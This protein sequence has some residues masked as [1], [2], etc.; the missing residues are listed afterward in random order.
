[1]ILAH[2]GIDHAEL[3]TVM[4]S[5]FT[6]SFTSPFMVLLIQAYLDK[7]RDKKNRDS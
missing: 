5:L 4:V 3:L 2:D 1:M 6:L 7:R